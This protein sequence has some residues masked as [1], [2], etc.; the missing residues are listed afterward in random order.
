MS[1]LFNRRE[2]LTGTTL[3][4][5]GVWLSNGSIAWAEG[6][7]PYEAINVANVGTDLLPDDREGVAGL[8]SALA[9]DMKAMRDMD[10]GTDEPA[11]IF[12]AVEK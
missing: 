8:L 2:A 9:S 5:L 12:E 7:S 1:Q 10:V 11:P 3:T 4:G 6:K